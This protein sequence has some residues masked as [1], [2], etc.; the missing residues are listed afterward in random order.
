MTHVDWADFMSMLEAVLDIP[1]G[2]MEQPGDLNNAPL[3]DDPTEEQLYVA[4]DERLRE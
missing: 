3:D 2:P 1:P 4:T